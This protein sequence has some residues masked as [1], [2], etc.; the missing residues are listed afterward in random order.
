MAEEVESRDM[1]RRFT[2]IDKDS[3]NVEGNDEAVDIR[4]RGGGDG[5]RGKKESTKIRGIF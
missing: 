2:M 5:G 3:E 4:E 1:R